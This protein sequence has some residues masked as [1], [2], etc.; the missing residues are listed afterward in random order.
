L[1]V[2][3]ARLLEP[4]ICAASPVDVAA[5]A[6]SIAPLTLGAHLTPRNRLRAPEPSLRALL[7][8]IVY[9]SCEDEPANQQ[10]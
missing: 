1:L 8:P 4:A 3:L 7:L 9:W 6:I 5:A 2:S 10:D